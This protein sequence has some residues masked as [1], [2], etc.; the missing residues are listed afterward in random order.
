M[1]GIDEELKRQTR[2]QVRKQLNERLIAEHTQKKSS[3]KPEVELIHSQEEYNINLRKK[4][5][6]VYI[7]KRPLAKVD[8]QIVVYFETTTVYFE[9]HAITDKRVINDLLRRIE[10]FKNKL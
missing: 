8:Q 1:S 4:K 3:I 10:A 7:K 5:F 6:T 9:G 2:V